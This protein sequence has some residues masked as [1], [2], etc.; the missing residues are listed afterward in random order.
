MLYFLSF[1]FFFENTSLVVQAAKCPLEES[2]LN[3]RSQNNTII[4][5]ETEILPKHIQKAFTEMR[6]KQQPQTSLY[7]FLSFSLPQKS[8]RLYLKEAKRYGARVVLRGFIGAS[9]RDTVRT[10]KTLIEETGYGV[11][12]DPTI[13]DQFT[14]EQ[15]PAFVLMSG[16]K[17]YDKIVGHIHLSYAL[18]QFAASGDLT[19]EAELF[20]ERGRQ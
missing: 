6:Q 2:A 4:V 12:I 7:L 16:T 14:V 1:F 11:Q 19:K 17:V 8:L 10:L 18:E 20:L 3:K 13:F 5:K 15:V 9:L